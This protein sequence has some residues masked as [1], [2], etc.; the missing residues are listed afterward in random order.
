MMSGPDRADEP[1]DSDRVDEEAAAIA[2][3]RIRSGAAEKKEDGAA[4]L[5][6]LGISVSAKDIL[7]EHSGSRLPREWP[8]DT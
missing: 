4:A 7:D 3:E 8:A 6:S 1:I 2:A 5:E